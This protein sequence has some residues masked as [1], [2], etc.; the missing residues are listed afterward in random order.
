MANQQQEKSQINKFY[1]DKPH[2]TCETEPN[3]DFHYSL[4]MDNVNIT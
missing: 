4:Q 2:S 3:V 1:G